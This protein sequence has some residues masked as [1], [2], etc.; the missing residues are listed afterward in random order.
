MLI[1]KTEAEKYLK[2]CYPSLELGQMIGHGAT[3]SVYEL[4]GIVPPQVIKIMD[5]DAL[6]PAGASVEH[7]K[8]MWQYF[9]REATNLKQMR[10]CRQIMSLYDWAEYKPPEERDKIPQF[11]SYKSVFLLRLERLQCLQEYLSDAGL[12]E[13]DLVRLGMDICL[14]LQCCE[15]HAVLHR[16]VKPDNIFVKP[17]GGEK[18]FV[19]GDFGFCREFNERNFRRLSICGTQA[20]QA[21]EVLTGKAKLGVYTSDI[22]SLGT[23]LFQL[24]SNGL[25]P[26]Y[27]DPGQ[28]ADRAALSK[29]A[30]GFADVILQ[31][32]RKEP[33]ERQQHA[34]D[35][36][37]QLEKL[38]PGASLQIV[39]GSAYLIMKQLMLN[40]KYAEAAETAREGIRKGESDCR[41]LLAYCMYNMNRHILATGRA[42]QAQAAAARHQ[43]VTAEKMLD[44]LV[45]EGDANA[46]Y[47]RAQVALQ[48]GDRKQFLLDI[49]EAAE[50]GSIL[51][52]YRYGRILYYGED[53]QK[54]P[55]K[56]F[57]L[58]RKA[59]E[60]NYLEAVRIVARISQLDPAT[61]GPAA[62]RYRHIQLDLTPRQKQEQ[63]IKFL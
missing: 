52:T 50:E 35:V 19:L 54:R 38:L 27:A 47:I 31:A 11:R 48:K 5:T 9:M 34:K 4:P 14:A 40:G 43:M 6:A 26:E 24:A 39:A 53:G 18:R 21:P 46:Q 8:R 42:S 33:A 56:G 17:E 16:D 1:K 51:A 15:E 60:A 2:A 7:R 62:N 57:H 59:A 3:A 32:V 58:L 29:I 61:A 30:P 25:F 44:Q 45:Y 36:Y 37:R 63:L 13:R 23:T 22:F 12:T 28:E 49:C 10:N 55:E 20:Y 41:R